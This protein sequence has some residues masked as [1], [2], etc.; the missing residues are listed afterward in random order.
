MS[1]RRQNNPAAQ[2]V[3]GIAVILLGLLFLL[4]NMGWLDLDLSVQFW[5]VILIVA[6]ALKFSQSQH[7][8]GRG[9]GVFLMLFG[10][11]ALLKGMGMLY[12]SWNVLAPLAMIGVGVLVVYR[13]VA[14]RQAADRAADKMA[15]ATSESVTDDENS[16]FAT[17][18]LGAYKRRMTS[19]RFAGG[20]ITTIM[21][22]C[23]LDLRDASIEGSAVLT[24]FALMGGI[25]I[26]VPTDWSV[27]LEGMPILGGFE[28]STLRPKDA[29]KRLVIRGYAIMGGLQIGN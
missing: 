5:P 10:G 7:G 2:I 25:E 19:Q 13:S 26:K 18:I 23:E 11:A 15:F 12:L 28:E 4:D 20:E 1:T 9:I 17:A 3:I 16:V 6:G 14:R 24:V 21:A 22:G 29:S 8:R 27:E